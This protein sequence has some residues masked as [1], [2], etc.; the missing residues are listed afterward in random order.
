MQNT[1]ISLYYETPSLGCTSQLN[2]SIIGNLDRRRSNFRKAISLFHPIPTNRT[3]ASAGISMHWCTC[4]K[5][6]PLNL[7]STE[8]MEVAEFVV[9]TIN[10]LLRNQWHC[11]SLTLSKVIEAFAVSENE[12]TL[13]KGGSDFERAEN[14][15]I[16]YVSFETMPG[17]ALF[18]STVIRTNNQWGLTEKPARINAYEGQS[19]CV[20]QEFKPFCFC[21]R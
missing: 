14:V 8:V 9:G 7:K 3:C 18:E 1:S 2:I 12:I 4:Y 16:R 15:K 5:K 13:D 11:Y 21:K 17:G 6:I 10:Y 20:Q 19:N